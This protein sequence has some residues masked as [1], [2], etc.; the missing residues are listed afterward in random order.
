MYC[1]NC[2]TEA[3][4]NAIVCIKCGCAL[5]ANLP[6]QTQVSPPN[7]VASLILG[8]ISFISTWFPIV[9][10]TCGIIGI[11]MSGKGLREYAKNQQI[12]S[13]NGL[14]VTGKVFSVI[15]V[16]LSSIFLVFFILYMIFIG[17]L[18]FAW[19]EIFGELLDF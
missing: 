19:W 8:I 18:A 2:G 15:G 5:K 1:L 17:G 14:L 12:Y 16:V 7:S 10:L 9:G 4:D 13:G 11:V 3:S 6:L